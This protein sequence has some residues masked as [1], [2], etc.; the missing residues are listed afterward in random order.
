MNS[1]P[2]IIRS[3]V[4]CHVQHIRDLEKE[5]EWYSTVLGIRPI[6]PANINDNELEAHE[7]F[8]GGTEHQHERSNLLDVRRQIYLYCG[9]L[10][11]VLDDLEETG[12]RADFLRAGEIRFMIHRSMMMRHDRILLEMRSYVH[13]GPNRGQGI[14]AIHAR[15]NC[16]LAVDINRQFANPRL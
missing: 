2:G 9:I 10:K 13:N 15:S 14:N 4:E 16:L 12:D 3:R 5:E 1:E 6:T 7:V 11:L 8:N